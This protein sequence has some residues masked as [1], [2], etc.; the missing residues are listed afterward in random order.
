MQSTTAWQPTE[1]HKAMY[2]HY[3]A[4]NVDHILR[5]T[6]G[7]DT[8]Y[9]M[10]IIAVASFAQEQA[11]ESAHEVWHLTQ[12]IGFVQTDACP[13]QLCP[14][15]T[16]QGQAHLDMHTVQPATKFSITLASLGA[17]LCILKDVLPE[18]PKD[19]RTLLGATMLSSNLNI[20]ESF[21]G[22]L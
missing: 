1:S 7:C 6:D 14:S 13:A 15:N 5:T 8:V 17:L 19:P 16:H 3:V 22:I 9:Y 20:K 11:A 4:N 18:L 10:G 2:D 12:K 21:R